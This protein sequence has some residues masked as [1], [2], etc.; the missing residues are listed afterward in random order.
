MRTVNR[1]FAPLLALAAVGAPMSTVTAQG[2]AAIALPPAGAVF[3]LSPARAL[4][5]IGRPLPPESHNAQDPADSLWRLA[6]R[7]N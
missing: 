2:R 3:A 7:A 1:I 5:P 4:R 6:R